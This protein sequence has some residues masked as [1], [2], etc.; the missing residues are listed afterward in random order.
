MI[1]PAVEIINFFET[2]P[3]STDGYAIGKVACPMDEKV[4]ILEICAEAQTVCELHGYYLGK[5]IDKWGGLTWPG[6]AHRVWR[7]LELEGGKEY[8]LTAD[9]KSAVVDAWVS[10]LL[11]IFREGRL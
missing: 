9:N 6:I 11:V 10:V 2:V 4:T 8:I 1:K 7:Q 3:I 5:E